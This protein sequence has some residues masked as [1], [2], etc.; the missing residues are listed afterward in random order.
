MAQV[1]FPVELGGDGSTVTDDTNANT[2]LAA[3]GHRERFVPALA[4]A[5]VMAGTAVNSAAAAKASEDTSNDHRIAA[6]A[7]EGK[8]AASAAAAAS[9]EAA[10]TTKADESAASAAEALQHLNNTAAVATGSTATLIAEAGKIPLADA[11]GKIDTD[12][13]QASTAATPDALPKA[14]DQGVV[15]ADYLGKEIGRI[16]RRQ[17]V[18]SRI[19]PSLD[20]DF[21][22]QSFSHYDG[23]K[24][25]EH[26][27]APFVTH[28]RAS[29]GTYFGPDGVMRSAANDQPRFDHDPATGEALG[30][31]VEESRT[32]LIKR[33][34]FGDWD[35]VGGRWKVA[36][37]GTFGTVGYYKLTSRDT[38]KGGISLLG[39]GYFDGY[40][41]SGTYARS[42]YLKRGNCRYATLSSYSGAHYFDFDTGTFGEGPAVPAGATCVAVGGGWYRYTYVAAETGAYGLRVGC[43]GDVKNSTYRD[44]TAGD[45][46]YI[47]APQAEKATFPTSYIPTK[48]TFVSRAS[49][50]TFFDS[51][52]V[53]QTAAINTA[54]TD[55]GYVNGRWLSKG[56]SVEA[57]ATNL[58]LHSSA[59]DNAYW[60]KVS[61]ATVTPNTLT[62][63]DG[64]TT[65]AT[66]NSGSSGRL[67]RGISSA[68][69]CTIS[70]YVKAK[71]SSTISIVTLGES[72]VVNFDL[73]AATAVKESG[74]G[75]C[76]IESVGNGWYRCSLK[77]TA[78]VSQVRLQQKN[79]TNG[80][81][82]IW[83]AQ[84]EEGTHATS[85]IPT[86]DSQV[87]RA[88]DVVSSAQATRSGDVATVD[89]LNNWYS[90]E[91]SSF[92]LHCSFPAV[93][94]GA[95]FFGLRRPSTNSSYTDNGARLRVDYS[96][97]ITT[98]AAVDNVLSQVSTPALY[99][100]TNN[101]VVALAFAANKTSLT[102]AHDGI[103]T[104][105]VTGIVPQAMTQVTFPSTQS[106][107]RKMSYYPRA[108]SSDDLVALTK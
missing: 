92:W 93:I 87:T 17:A 96:R 10:A 14:D 7:S 47:A 83:G 57:A 38:V 32:N 45:Y 37:A 50:K 65:A 8:A 6:A 16:L 27:Y 26:D 4:Q 94:Q 63:P 102:M 40:P 36:W 28:T 33:C 53:L 100:T 11:E 85:Y 52:G 79:Q 21:A 70:I 22:N 68:G 61:D 108:L 88:A 80:E 25:V 56:L 75:S 104:S 49:T 46:V 19:K 1:T 76:A 43:A 20:L 2:G 95:I 41:G 24:Y 39:S 62:A 42:I 3:G 59:F 30:L 69:A 66:F 98:T 86:N 34:D 58:L 107:Y 105:S 18:E 90:H 82:Y 91:Q 71:I 54:A 12:W 64:T 31:L 44:V 101:Q 74:A 89:D 51:N 67:D 99:L 13:L 84:L 5:V 35:T 55:H 72:N 73:A 81:V 48:P 106:H 103:A 60:T 77:T 15:D 23:E 97:Q 9:S 29:N 78:A